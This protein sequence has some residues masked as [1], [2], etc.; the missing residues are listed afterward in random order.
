MQS[1]KGEN[2]MGKISPIAA[3]YTIRAKLKA[4]GVIE[5][6]D[7]V[8]AVFGQTEGLLGSDLELRELQ[9]SG[10]IGRIEVTVASKGGKT[11]GEI[12]IPSSMDKVET[13]IIGAAI[14]TID[15]IG[16]CTAELKVQLIED[17]RS[18]KRRFVLER[19]KELLRE[20]MSGV[21]HDSQEI[22]DAVKNS[23]RVSE[24]VD[25]GP[26]KIPAGPLVDS[27]DELI[28]VEGRADVINLLKHGFKNVVAIDGTRV[29]QGVR[30]L[31]KN[32]TVTLFVD[33]DRGGDLILKEMLQVA[34]VDFIARAT[35]GREVEEISQKE[36]HKALRSREP[37]TNAMLESAGVEGKP[38]NNH[39]APRQNTQR[40]DRSDNRRDKRRSSQDSEYDWARAA[41][42]IDP[43]TKGQLNTMADDLIGTRGAYLLDDKHGILGKV[44][45]A[46]LQKTLDNIT[47]VSAIVL[48][49]MITKKLAMIAQDKNVRILVGS[50]RV[51]IRRPPEGMIILTGEELA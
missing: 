17:V 25:Y 7:V 24:L 50:K 14:E 1:F 37:I 45:V 6:P 18:S 49:G 34:D 32:H 13:A 31:T 42:N 15:R 26:E 44:P 12:E 8:G 39:N 29:P 30:D 20:M 51:G 2:I 36:I 46:E 40:K 10:R 47:G 19:A 48:D 35:P 21:A 4:E 27:T 3:K 22:T 5:K 41:G 16:P 11:R 38:S 9:K 23:V 28:V 43:D 33:G